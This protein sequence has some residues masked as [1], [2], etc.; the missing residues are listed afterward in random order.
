MGDCPMVETMQQSLNLCPHSA[1]PSHSF[2][3]GGYIPPSYSCPTAS[4]DLEI[5]LPLRLEVSAL[6]NKTETKEFYVMPPAEKNS[7]VL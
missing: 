1:H 5:S 3:T 2:E 6:L 4:W 7:A